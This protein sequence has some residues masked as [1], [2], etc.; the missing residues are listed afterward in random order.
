MKIGVTGYADLGRPT[1]MLVRQALVEALEPYAGP[2]LV[3]IS[4][5]CRG[6]D[7]LFA[8]A[9]IEASGVLDVILPAR[10]YRRRILR[11]HET[12]A[13]D[14][15]LSNARRIRHAA[16]ASNRRAYAR[17]GR[18]L[19]KE[20]EVLFAVWDGTPSRRTGDTADVVQTAERLGVQVNVIWPDRA[21]RDA[22]HSSSDS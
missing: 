4:C 15:L 6:A 5:L 19:V 13:F 14:Q 16:G 18:L 11:Y 7:Q 3:G 9:V 1:Q 22:S 2:N 12:A 21:V 8:S 20:C 10:D 17:A